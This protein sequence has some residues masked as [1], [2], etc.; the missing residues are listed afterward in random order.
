MLPSPA[1]VAV[2]HKQYL[3]GVTGKKERNHGG[4]ARTQDRT[5]V[6]AKPG[7]QSGNRH[8]TRQCDRQDGRV[9]ADPGHDRAQGHRYPQALFRASAISPTTPATWRPAPA[10]S[11][12]PIS[13]ATRAC[14]SIA[15]IRSRSWPRTAISW[16]SCYL[17]LNGELPTG[18]QKTEVR[19]RTSPITPW[20]MSSCRSFF[21]G[22]RRDAHPMA[23]M[24]GVVGALSAFYHD[25]HRHHRPRSAHDRLLPPD[26]QDADHRGHGLQIF[27]R[28][29]FHLSAQ[30]TGLSPRISCT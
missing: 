4:Q 15:A 13:T 16:R 19:Q 10:R 5:R 28:P 30:R 21:R 11:R 29:A 14:C 9:A 25:S 6:P 3:I 1:S 20:C 17:L 18:R 23:V 12:S 22:F 27:A 7:E 8:A 26:R 2:Q 24:C